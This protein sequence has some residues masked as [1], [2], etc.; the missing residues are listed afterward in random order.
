SRRE[1][2]EPS[3]AVG[4]RI[5]DAAIQSKHFLFAFGNGG[6]RHKSCRFERE[7]NKPLSV[8]FVCNRDLPWFF[9][10]AMRNPFE[11]AGVVALG[12]DKQTIFA[13]TRS[14]RKALGCKYN[15]L[16]GFARLSLG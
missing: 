12:P 1:I 14:Q 8:R 3:S 10:L 4:D 16:G 2:I 13:V 7:A 6:F 11:N 5:D 9:V 15:A